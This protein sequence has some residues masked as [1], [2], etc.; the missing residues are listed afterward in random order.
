MAML[1]LLEIDIQRKVASC[2][3]VFWKQFGSIALDEWSNSD[4]NF[5]EENNAKAVNTKRLSLSAASDSKRFK[6]AKTKDIKE[7]KQPNPPV[8]TKW[9][10]NWAVKNLQT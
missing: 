7:A 1:S 8:N 3:C 5:E 6:R 9:N 10:M 4:S 2:S